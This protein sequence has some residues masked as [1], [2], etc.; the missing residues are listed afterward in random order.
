MSHLLLALLAQFL[1]GVASGRW[2]LGGVVVVAFY[3]GREFTQAEY[4]WIAAFGEGQRANMPLLAGFDA[5]VWNLKSLSD[6]LLP[7]AGVVVLY[8]VVRVLG[9]R[10]RL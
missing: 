1:I 7:L 9:N 10:R 3:V 8:M 6:F 2:L 4:R 5:R